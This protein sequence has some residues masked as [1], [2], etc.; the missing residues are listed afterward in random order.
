MY[1]H[2]CIIFTCCIILN[3]DVVVRDVA[4]VAPVLS[5][6]TYCCRCRV[7][8]LGGYRQYNSKIVT[9]SFL[10]YVVPLLIPRLSIN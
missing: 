1:T 9:S 3:N 10:V 2:T 4:C 5:L 8:I 6:C 7:H